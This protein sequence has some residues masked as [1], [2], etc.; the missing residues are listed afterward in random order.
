MP[1][2]NTRL[3]LGTVQFG[4]PYGISNQSGQISHSEG[5]AILDYAWSVGMDTL[6][7]A[8]AYGDSEQRLGDVGLEQWRVVSKLPAR[9]DGQAVR[10][11]V[12][13][14]LLG[15]LARLGLPKLGG[16]L[17]HQ[18]R[19]LL[20]KQG[21]ALYTALVD[22]KTAGKVEKIGI[23]VYDPAELDALCPHFDFDLIQAPL[24][25]VDRRLISSGWLDRMVRAGIEVHARSIFLQGL[26]LMDDASRP[27]KFSRWNPLWAN[28]NRWLREHEL[29]ALQAC[30]GFALSQPE[31]GRVVVG[32]DG[33]AHLR[34]IVAAATANTISV[35]DTLSCEDP[36]LIN[37]SQ[38][39]TF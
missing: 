2:V 33:L 21:E 1:R 24:N 39:S 27:A 37:P 23:S 3:A 12:N 25:I 13:D 7:T 11:W 35:P 28:W 4:L 30:L 26:L 17:L 5:A 9:P 15:S 34:Q 16:L 22:L 19:A 10:E 8:V 20:N 32:V 31:I 6:D 18:P 29:S 36:N 38:W 14:S